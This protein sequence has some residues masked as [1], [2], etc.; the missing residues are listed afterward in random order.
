MVLYDAGPHDRKSREPTKRVLGTD[1]DPFP[2]LIL[3]VL[4]AISN[5]KNKEPLDIFPILLAR[6]INSMLS[7][8]LLRHL[9]HIDPHP[10]CLKQL[11]L[12]PNLPYTLHQYIGRCNV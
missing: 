1:A 5:Q 8:P 12:L 2:N 4:M 10:V 9:S 11:S 3:I 6:H 7:T